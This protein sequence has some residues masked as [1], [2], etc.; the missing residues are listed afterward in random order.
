MLCTIRHALIISLSF[1]PWLTE[2]L[3]VDNG[4]GWPPS[5]A[6]ALSKALSA[7]SHAVQSPFC[8][9]TNIR[10]A[11]ESGRFPLAPASDSFLPF[12]PFFL[13]SPPSPPDPAAAPP[14]APSAPLAPSAGLSDFPSA[15]LSPLP[16][17]DA[18]LSVLSL[19]LPSS[20]LSLSCRNIVSY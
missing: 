15:P 10:K 7:C 11:L 1:L 18:F 20:F 2:S 16:A 19:S 9:R 12:L 13:P 14:A 4:L 5:S 17:A 6:E 8:A 3:M